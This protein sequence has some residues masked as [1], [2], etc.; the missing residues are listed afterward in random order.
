MQQQQVDKARI[1]LILGVN[2]PL[3]RFLA[4]SV[5]RAC[6]PPKGKYKLDLILLTTV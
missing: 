5:V 4:P 3:D 2:F 1:P 6:S